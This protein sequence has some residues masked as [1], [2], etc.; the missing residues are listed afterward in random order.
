M[1]N[2]V[3]LL[4]NDSVVAGGF[5]S[6]AVMAGGV[7]V[8]GWGGNRNGELGLGAVGDAF[9][10]VVVTALEGKPLRQVRVPPLLDKG[11]VLK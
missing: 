5:H 7:G 4:S 9:H 1:E 8:M 2:G 11:S 10:P 6:L 3:N